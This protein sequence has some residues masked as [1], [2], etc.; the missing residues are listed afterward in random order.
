MSQENMNSDSPQTSFSFTPIHEIL[1][2]VGFDYTPQLHGTSGLGYA[3]NIP[4]RTNL[5]LK[6][7]MNFKMGPNYNNCS[8]FVGLALTDKFKNKSLGVYADIGLREYSHGDSG[9]QI[10][11]GFSLPVLD[12]PKFRQDIGLSSNFYRNDTTKLSIELGFS[13]EF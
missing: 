11:Y 7:H 13:R 8:H 2:D 9:I 1:S 6:N 3:W 4:L 12:D 5:Y 10:R